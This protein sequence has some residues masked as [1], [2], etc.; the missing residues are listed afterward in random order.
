MRKFTDNANIHI[1]LK[2]I[3]HEYND[4]LITS[5]IRPDGD[6]VGS[7]LGLG[8]ALNEFGKNVQL[9][10][11]D[12]VPNKFRFLNSSELI[13]THIQNNYEV[14][15]VLDC[16]DMK[17]LGK[18]FNNKI[19]D[20]NIDHHITNEN[21]ARINLVDTESSATSAI[22]AENMAHW[23][24]TISKTCAEA[25][26]M[27]IITDTIGFRTSNMTAKTLTLAAQLMD[28]G[29]DIT[30]IYNK[31]LVNQNMQSARL[32]GLSLCKLQ[33]KDKLIYTSITL[34]D[35]HKAGYTGKDDADLTNILSTIEDGE[36]SILFN[37]QSNDCVKVSWRSNGKIN[38]ATLAQQFGGGGHPAA[39]GAEV[40]GSLKNTISRVLEETIKYQNSI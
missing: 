29:A 30:P 17:R 38:V 12:G 3:L 11:T 20:V 4:F 10:L 13:K 6:A 21:F 5:H 27:G 25:L 24:L 32:W 16:A 14:L 37:E 19:P 8:I 22:L 26:L 35:R 40:K 2:K 34:D 36:I 18:I 9:V 28:F 31:A 1:D 7:I 33:K 23:G 15:I 39:A